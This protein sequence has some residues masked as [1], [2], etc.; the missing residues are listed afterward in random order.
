VSLY[1]KRGIAYSAKGDADKMVADF[2]EVID[3]NPEGVNPYTNKENPCSA[4]GGIDR[5]TFDFGPA[6]ASNRD[7]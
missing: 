5:S 3:L 4:N 6:S 7:D 1:H 2:N